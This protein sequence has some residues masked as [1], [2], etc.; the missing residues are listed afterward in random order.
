VTR[1]RVNRRQYLCRAIFQYPQCG[2]SW[3]R[4]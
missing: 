1:Y 3:R 4:A 2:W